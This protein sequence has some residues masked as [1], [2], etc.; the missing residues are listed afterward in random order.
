MST[1]TLC[2]ADHAWFFPL[3]ILLVDMNLAPSTSKIH[4]IIEFNVADFL[5]LLC[6]SLKLSLLLSF[7]GT[8]NTIGFAEE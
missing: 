2:K 4:A 8:N 7:E 6:L 5:G 3:D 1:Y